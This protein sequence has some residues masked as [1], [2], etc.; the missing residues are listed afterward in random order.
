MR[1]EDC[2]L[3][4]YIA[5]VHGYKGDV[6]F[7]LDVTNPNEYKSLDAVFIEMQPDQLIPFFIKKMAI[8]P[9]KNFAKVTLEDVDTEDAAKSIVRKSLYLPLTSLPE[10]TG[11][12]F[13]DHEIVGYTIL[14]KNLGELGIIKNILDYAQNPLFEIDNNGTELLFP[15]NQ[16]FII[17]LNREKKEITI[18]APDGYFDMF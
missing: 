4:G 15:V 10:L 12:E 18:E 14:D 9:H 17:D 16:K 11:T 6:S 3:L 7:F 1:K 8:S 5:K 13:Y 2:Y